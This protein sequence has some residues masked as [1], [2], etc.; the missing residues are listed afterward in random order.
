MERSTEYVTVPLKVWDRT[1]S[2]LLVLGF[3]LGVMVGYCFG[4]FLR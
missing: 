4:A 2:G 3:G 1:R